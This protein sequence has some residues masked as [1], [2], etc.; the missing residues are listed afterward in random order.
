MKN[1]FQSHGS[2]EFKSGKESGLWKAIETKYA[3]ELASASWLRKQR[4]KIEMQLEFHRRRNEGHA[5]SP[6][7]L[8]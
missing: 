7:T 8:W 1:G 2:I 5:P 4:L 3:A 6:A